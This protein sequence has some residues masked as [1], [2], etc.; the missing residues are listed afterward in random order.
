M[1]DESRMKIPCRS[2]YVEIDSREA[3]ILDSEPV[4]RLRRIRQL[5]MTHLVYPG[6]TH[7]R[8]EH[9]IGVMDLAGRLAESLGLNDEEYDKYRLAGLL[10]DT[11]HSPFSHALEEISGDNSLDHEERSCRKVD[12][13][14]DKLPEGVT[15]EGVK[16]AIRGNDTHNIIAGAVDAD[17]LDYLERD[18]QN[19]GLNQGDIDHASL[20]QFAEE[21]D[22]LGDGDT[23]VFDQKAVPALNSFFTARISMF[24]SVYRHPA[25][26]R[27]ERILLE[28]ASEL[29][30]NEECDV[31]RET[32][33]EMDEHTLGTALRS[34]Q[35]R[36]GELYQKLIGREENPYPSVTS[37]NLD[38]NDI[39]RS[40]VRETIPDVS[41][42]AVEQQLQE[43]LGGSS[44]VLVHLP[45]LPKPVKEKDDVYVSG[46]DDIVTFQSVS[47]FREAVLDEEWRATRVSVYMKKPEKNEQISSTDIREAIDLA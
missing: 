39:D 10:H 42:G 9:S 31:T 33:H 26:T 23:L 38:K 16:E 8:F 21:A 4:Q 17:R 15:A 7:T 25:V 32:I 35:G 41:K 11:G 18:A 46:D 24:N 3:K 22:P 29:V 20:I 2:R 13:L 45:T 36:A 40:R 6:A 44:D 19:V 14:A 28:A 1:S 47:N 12:D 30:E 5:A 27:F 43:V 37:L 34:S